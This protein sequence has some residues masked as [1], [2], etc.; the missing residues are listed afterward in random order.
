MKAL[1]GGKDHPATRPTDR[2]RRTGQQSVEAQLLLEL[3]TIGTAEQMRGLS[4]AAL[5]MA[6]VMDDATATPQHPAAAGQLR[7]I[8][9]D[10]RAGVGKSKGRGKLQGI[11]GGR[12]GTA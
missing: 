9:K 4:A 2:K 1:P 5:A 10:I 8:L 3:A 11:R 7:M 6:R 12:A